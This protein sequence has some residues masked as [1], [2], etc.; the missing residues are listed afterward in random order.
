MHVAC[1]CVCIF[2]IGVI[3]A[4]LSLALFAITSVVPTTKKPVWQLKKKSTMYTKLLKVHNHKLVGEI[5][6]WKCEC[7][8]LV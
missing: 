5:E 7:I 1:V 3:Y 8:A 4:D 2:V 6:P